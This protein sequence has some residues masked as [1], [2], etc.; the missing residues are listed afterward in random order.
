MSKRAYAQT[1]RAERTERT[2][3][4]I[5]DGVQGLF[6]EEGVFD[7]PLPAVAERAG[8]STRTILRHFGSKEGLIGAAIEDASGR[9]ER[10]RSAAPGDV[11]T[12]IARLVDHY[13]ETGERTM[14]LLAEAE[15]H[16]LV[17]R[18]VEDGKALHR[19]WVEH[20]FAP[21]LDRDERE[22]ERQLALLASVTD[23]YVWSL[24]RKRYGR[25]KQET[26][27]AIRDLVNHAM[28]RSG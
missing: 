17:A 22:R 6:L 10:S 27:A 3:R 12:A 20:V 16:P 8:T 7:P 25:S 5:L 2:R 23:L 28:G 19:D 21:L 13:E 4:A 11:E 9:V 26:E 1:A 24:L 18:V 14:R 15:R